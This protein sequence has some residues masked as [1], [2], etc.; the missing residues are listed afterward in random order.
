MTAEEPRV[1]ITNDD[2]IDTPGLRRLAAVLS[3]EFDVFVAAPADDMS[4]SGTG[5]GRFEPD[6]GVEMTPVEI[7]EA[8][9][10][11]IIDGPPGL[12]VTAA[13]MGAFGPE[14]DMV[15]SGINA[16]I[17]TGHSIIHSGTVGAALTAHTFKMKG[18][19]VSLD[20]SDPWHWDTATRYARGA[21]HWLVNRTEGPHVLNVN[22]PGVPADEVM[23]VHWAD[24]DE[25]GSVRVA[26]N[27]V[28]GQRL[29]LVVGNRRERSD[30]ASDTVLCL[31]N[32][33][34]VTPLQTVEPAPF[35]DVE[36]GAIFDLPSPAIR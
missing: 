29:Q 24:L 26:T 27:D 12:A 6:T 30:P 17:N 8:P 25:F 18:L 22:V 35:P 28:D 7:D 33:V 1:M 10:A 2:G 19:A 4:G 16:G 9:A 11:Y 23:G 20:Q 3:D 34:T 32:Y 5:I 36:A 14:P 15:V 21:A 31:A 13:A